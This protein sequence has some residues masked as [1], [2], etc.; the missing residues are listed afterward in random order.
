MQKELSS[1]DLHYL[2]DEFQ[3]LIGAKIEQI[4]QIGK[5][6]LFFQFHVPSKGKHLLRVQLGKLIYF[7]TSKTGIPEKPPG[8]CVYLRKRL[9]NARLREIKQVGF[10]RVIEILLETKDQKY[11]LIIESFSTGNIILCDESNTILSPLERQEWKDRSIRSKEIYKLP[12]REHKIL[13]INQQDLKSILIKSDKESLVKS[14]AIE[15]SLGGT[16]AEEVCAL[17][18]VDKN[19]KPNQLSDKE[20]EDIFKAITIILNAD[21]SPQIIFKDDAPKD[22]TPIQLTIYKD[23][24]SL[25]ADSF[26]S[27]LDSILTKK[28]ENEELKHTEKKGQTKL[29]KIE[30]MIKEQQY[31]IDGLEVSADENQKKGE[32]IYENYPL[33]DQILKTISEKRKEL[34]WKEIKEALKNHKIIKSI[35]EKTGDI[36]VEL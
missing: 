12:A 36:T 4:Y 14:L 3:V 9:K 18:K 27:A 10:E 20:I 23:F 29:N 6:E 7:A 1:L 13:E 33:A 25:P 11:K 2:I 22:I 15:F 34:S 19:L 16:Y 30:K 26:N 32:M 24:K 35:D 31:R 28:A 21:A 17:S 5:E 8:F